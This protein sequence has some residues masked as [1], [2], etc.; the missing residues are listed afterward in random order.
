MI[1]IAARACLGTLDTCALQNSTDHY[2]PAGKE[3]M[4]F[5]D[6]TLVGK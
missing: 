2:S 1:P 6:D 5:D 4:L 3:L